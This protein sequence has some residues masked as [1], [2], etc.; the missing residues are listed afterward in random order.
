MD[1]SILKKFHGIQ[2]SIIPLSSRYYFYLASWDNTPTSIPSFTNIWLIS[3]D[4]HRMLLSY[5]PKSSEIVCIYHKFDEIIDSSIS[6][7]WTDEN[8]LQINCRSIDGSK[9]LM[10]DIKFKETLSSKI[11]ISL[12]AGP[13]TP[14]RVSNPMVKISDLLINKIVAISGSAFIGKT[15]TGKPFYHGDTERILHITEGSAKY[16]GEYLGEIT[17]PT[18][19][20]SFGD[21]VPF[22]RPVIKLGS[23]YIPYEAGMLK[24]NIS[25]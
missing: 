12:A 20:I 25:P 16:N 17:N 2:S 7:E 23:L 1:P 9:E 3:P 18:W 8:S 19:P 13:P 21:A 15:E 22:F 4:N 11:L 24:E 10:V 6:V 5:P 14:L